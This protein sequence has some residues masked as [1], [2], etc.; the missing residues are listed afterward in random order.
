MCILDTITNYS[1]S[2]NNMITETIIYP[3]TWT[4]IDK[5]KT[6]IHFDRQVYKA[7]LIELCST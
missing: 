5:Y 1:E 7:K 6:F 2:W 4:R 3:D